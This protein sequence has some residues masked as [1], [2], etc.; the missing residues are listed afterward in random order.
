[1]KNGLQYCNISIFCATREHCNWHPSWETL[2]KR[3]KLLIRFVFLV[4][5]NPLKL[6]TLTSR[7]YTSAKGL[8][9]QS[10][11]QNQETKFQSRQVCVYL[12]Q[13]EIHCTTAQCRSRVQT[14]L[15]TVWKQS[16]QIGFSKNAKSSVKK[17]QVKKLT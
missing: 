5:E 11:T 2:A 6:N 13:F 12:Q 1:M 8:K 16:C 4:Y 7:R 17:C 10:N 15:E 3:H 14:N 9:F